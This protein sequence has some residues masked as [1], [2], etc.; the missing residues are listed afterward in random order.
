MSS[1]PTLQQR[2]RARV[3]ASLKDK[4]QLDGLLGVGGTAAVYAATHR[5]GKRAAIK[6]LHPE[7]STND[8]LVARFLR[9]GYVANK[10]E[11]P[12]A[13]SVLDDDRTDDGAV[14]LVMELLDGH[15]LEK[16]TKANGDRLSLEQV[17]RVGD[18][19]LDVLAVAHGKGVIHR[20]IKPANLFLTR[21]GRVKVLDF[22]IARLREGNNDAT[23]T[24]T[25]AAIGTPA[26]MPPEQARG[27]W[28]LVDARTDVWSVGATLFALL[29]G[30]RPR[31]ADT[32]NEEL[33]LAMTEPVPRIQTIAPQVP[34]VVADVVDRALAFEMNDRFVDARAMQQALRGALANLR[35]TADPET[36][37]SVQIDTAPV[38]HGMDNAATI[39]QPTPISLPANPQPDTLDPRLT[40]S[41]PIVAAEQT[42]PSARK[43]S[44]S[45]AAIAVVFGVLAVGA[46]GV[47][48]FFGLR[49]AR[50]Q[51]SPAVVANASPP[52]AAAKDDS[53]KAQGA[54]TATATATTAANAAT[55]PATGTS[56]TPTTS[57]ADLPPAN[58]GTKVVPK[59]TARPNA[60][61][62]P[63]ATAAGTGN[64][65]D[66][67][68]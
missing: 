18:E 62:K 32:V 1:G 63:T 43:R 34:Q 47:G 24:Q 52:A 30:R 55:P 35:E 39:A 58:T 11:H 37:L 28:H 53:A 54:A 64:P 36:L 13:V 8:E 38:L 45:K 14:F 40:T 67:R 31:K 51:P 33:L 56:S 23:A 42:A 21:D 65:W 25:G 27:R 44:G 2:A 17:I 7:L 59:G 3:G 57:I 50:S 19:T 61:T 22:G 60:S 20:D 49:D 15:S 26:F 9:E 12:G 16:H 6:M 4:W 48:A 46:I 29:T 5:N 10:L 41:R 68:F 66:S